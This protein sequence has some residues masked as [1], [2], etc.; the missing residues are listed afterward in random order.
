MFFEL[1]TDEFRE[2]ISKTTSDE[3]LEIMNLKKIMRRLSGSDFNPDK[4]IHFLNLE[5]LILTLQYVANHFDQIDDVHE[6]LAYCFIINNPFKKELYPITRADLVPLW[7]SLDENL[8]KICMEKST[9]NHDLAKSALRHIQSFEDLVFVNDHVLDLRSVHNIYEIVPKSL[10]H[11]LSGHFCLEIHFDY[12]YVDLKTNIMG[13][14][15]KT[16]DCISIYDPK[17]FL[18]FIDLFYEHGFKIAITT[19][20]MVIVSSEYKFWSDSEMSMIFS[21]IKN[22]DPDLNSV[23]LLNVNQELIQLIRNS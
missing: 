7:R 20:L 10:H 15:Q 21:I 2:I 9:N 6:Y 11:V 17:K 1:P 4:F 13:I 8:F 18:E 23:G 16:V 19:E 3:F 22:T 12:K 14:T 5:N